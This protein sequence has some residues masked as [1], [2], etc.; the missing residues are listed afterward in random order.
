MTVLL[1]VY[2]RNDDSAHQRFVSIAEAYEALSDP[3]TR[4]VYDRYGHEGL[5]QHRQGGGPR[6]HD[7]FD[8]F[9][10]FFG[11]GGHFGGSGQRRG[12]DMELRINLPLKDF[13]TGNEREFSVEKQEICEACEGSGS[14]DGEVKHCSQCGGNGMVIQKH[15]LAPGIFQQIQMACDKCGGKGKVV[16]TPC[17]E[18]GGSRVVRKTSTYNLV[19]ERGAPRGSRVLF[20]N[21]ADASPDWAA[22]DLIVHLEEMEPEMDAAEETR[23]DGAFFRRNANDMFWKEVLSLREAWMGGWTRNLTHLD[24]HVVQLS[25]KKGETVQPSTVEVIRGEGMP[26]PAEEQPHQED[27]FGTLHVEYAV[28]LPDQ[29]ETE[30]EREFSSLWEKWRSKKMV[31]LAKDSG[32]PPPRPKDEL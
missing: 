1:R 14:A 16:T 13:Y 25:R 2:C 9:S 15:M 26:F 5:A 27:E 11:G 10:H 4:K 3:E 20:E 23:M 21:E 32:R 6:H 8:L 30:M 24:G 7:P 28:I 19:V 17:K 18:C 22:G 12:P 31:D 29:M